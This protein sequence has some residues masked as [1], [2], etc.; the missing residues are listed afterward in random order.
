MPRACFVRD[1]ECES[2]CAN[3]LSVP[4]EAWKESFAPVFATLVSLRQS[5]ISWVA[6]LPFCLAWPSLRGLFVTAL[7]FRGIQCRNLDMSNFYFRLW[8]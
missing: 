7:V 5:L 4:A 2:S 1:L 8:T 6:L 3:F